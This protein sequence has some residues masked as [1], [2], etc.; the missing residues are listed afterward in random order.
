MWWEEKECTVTQRQ[1][2][3]KKKERDKADNRTFQEK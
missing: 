1:V 2:V 3:C